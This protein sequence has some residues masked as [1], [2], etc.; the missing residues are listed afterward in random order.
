MKRFAYLVAL[1]ASFTF[2]TGT[3]ARGRRNHPDDRATHGPGAVTL[4]QRVASFVPTTERHTVRAQS[5]SGGRP[6]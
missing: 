2:F 6:T 1:V 5:P 4:E 3:T